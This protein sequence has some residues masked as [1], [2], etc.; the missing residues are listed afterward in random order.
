MKRRKKK[1]SSL[2]LCV[3]LN[4]QR[5]YC[6]ERE[7]GGFIFLPLQAATWTS[8]V[9]GPWVVVR[10]NM[11]RDKTRLG[12]SK[13]CRVLPGIGLF[14]RWLSGQEEEELTVVAQKPEALRHLEWNWQNHFVCM[15]NEMLSSHSK[16]W[17][18]G[19]EAVTLCG[20]T[21]VISIIAISFFLWRYNVPGSVI[22]TLC[23]VSSSP[24]HNLVL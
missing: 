15:G 4:F 10:G 9:S 1:K 21:P 7:Q 3:S 18:P 14:W 2:Y 20:T 12:S 19:E 11:S 24:N 22:S 23:I 6:P 5:S 13:E 8:K 16:C 17:L